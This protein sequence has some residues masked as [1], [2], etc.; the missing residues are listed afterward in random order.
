MKTPAPAAAAWNPTWPRRPAAGRLRQS[1]NA[2][3]L[4]G[5][6]VLAFRATGIK[7]G[8]L[9]TGL[10][11]MWNLV[12][13]MWPPDL[14]YALRIIDPL[15]VT[16]RLAVGATVLG[17]LG[18]LPF[19]LLAAGNLVRS[20]LVYHTVRLAGNLLR[21]VPELALAAVLVAVFGIGV[22]PGLL[23]VAIFSFA[24]L[25]KLM[26]EFT[27][28]IDP[29]PLEALRATGANWLQVAAYAVLPQIAAAFVSYTLYVFEVNVRV[30]FVLGWVGAGGIGRVIYTDLN[31]LHYQRVMTT[32]LVI[33]AVVLI[34]DLVSNALRRRLE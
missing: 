2:A 5:C 22:L 15:V 8:E 6:V 34:I 33:F 31:F 20:R 9:L 11:A 19:A 27:E 23:A 30:A 4:A 7:P 26:S 18:S 10:P 1:L 13:R 12:E 25:I 16:L 32:V 29:G 14:A 28:T 17:A 24:I 21:T 3:C